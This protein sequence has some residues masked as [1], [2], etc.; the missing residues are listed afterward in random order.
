MNNFITYISASPAEVPSS[1][2]VEN[3]D[4]LKMLAIASKAPSG[5]NTQPWQFKVNGS[6]IEIHPDFSKA[7]PV[8]DGNNRELY[9][10]LGCLTANFC[11][12]AKELYYIPLV[13]FE[14][15]NNDYAY[16][17]IKLIQGN[18]LK[19][20]LFEQIEKRQTNRGEY[21]NTLIPQEKI[22]RLK[23]MLTDD[24]IK[25][26]FF[27]KDSM[28][29]LMLRDLIERANTIQMKDS[30]FKKELLNWIRFNS[31]EENRCK[32]GLSYRVMGMPAAPG[33]LGKQIVKAFLKPSKQNSSDLKKLDSSSH[34]V[35]FS[36]CENSTENWIRLGIS[37]QRFLLES[38]AFGISAAWMNQPCEV[39]SVSIAL[40]NEFH[41]YNE[42]PAI[43]LRI[44]YGGQKEF[45]LR[46]ER[47]KF[48]NLVSGPNSVHTRAIQ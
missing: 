1:L 32:T 47:Q 24:S 38:T 16:I 39:E 25:A 17:K 34:L 33:F 36:C 6:S 45:S 29:F 3:S 19:D 2:E 31:K 27:R 8:V 26:R 30:A 35:L 15:G 40:R 20:P 43:L 48:M 18:T 14:S 44:G 7:L 22:G 37:L 23:Y 12:A 4:I 41:I 9:I 10:S 42:Y 21:D 13:S 5:H 28:E 46:E 11:I